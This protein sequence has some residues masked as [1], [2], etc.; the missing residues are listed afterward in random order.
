MRAG[1]QK[2]VSNKQWPNMSSR[3]VAAQAIALLSFWQ[4]RLLQ[5]CEGESV[6]WDTTAT[7]HTASLN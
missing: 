2:H 5:G 4:V 6:W 1:D 3:S 7:N